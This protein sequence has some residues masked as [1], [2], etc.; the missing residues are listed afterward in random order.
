YPPQVKRSRNQKQ[1]K[2][3]PNPRKSGIK[4]VNLRQNPREKKVRSENVFCSHDAFCESEIPLHFRNCLRTSA[5]LKYGR[6]F[7]TKISSFKTNKKQIM[8]NKTEKPKAKV[9]GEN[10]NVFSLIGI[11][12]NGS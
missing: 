12:S 8:E 7:F 1:Q 6:L 11:C 2:C 10:A 5:A 3:L 4:W 9:L